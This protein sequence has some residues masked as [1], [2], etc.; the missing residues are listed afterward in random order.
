[1][2]SIDVAIARIIT[3]WPYNNNVLHPILLAFYT[4]SSACLSFLE[5]VVSYY[6][7]HGKLRCRYRGAYED[8]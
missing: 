2:L 7:S 4:T 1:M 8:G 3:N 5:M 6:I